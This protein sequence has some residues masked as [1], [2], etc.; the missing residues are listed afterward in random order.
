[1][2]L[3]LVGRPFIL[4]CDCLPRFE[5]VELLHKVGC[6]LEFIEVSGLG[7]T[8]TLSYV[9]YARKCLE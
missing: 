6:R 3:R 8:A 1:M 9:Y 4:T 2:R 7:G 5:V